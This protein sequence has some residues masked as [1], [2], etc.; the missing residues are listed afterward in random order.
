M[1]FLLRV[2]VCR[3]ADKIVNGDIR[4]S[5]KTSP[6]QKKEQDRER[7]GCPYRKDGG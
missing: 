5:N 7:E 6:L 2:N 1:T 4:R 3:K